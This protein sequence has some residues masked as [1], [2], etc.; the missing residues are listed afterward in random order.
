VRL[1]PL[2]QWE[3]LPYRLG[4]LPCCRRFEV[5]GGSRYNGQVFFHAK[6]RYGSLVESLRAQVTEDVAQ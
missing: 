1:P 6:H 3:V 2:L 4:E 5:Y